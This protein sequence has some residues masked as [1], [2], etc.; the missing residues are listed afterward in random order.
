[1]NIIK[2]GRQRVILPI[3]QPEQVLLDRLY[4][5]DGAWTIQEGLD[6]LG[7]DRL[8]AMIDHQCLGVTPT[9]MGDLLL[10]LAHGRIATY[11]G[12]SASVSLNGQIN[13]AYFRLSL[14]ALG[15]RYPQPGEPVRNLESYDPTGRFK[16]VNTEFGLALVAGKLTSDGYSTD[17][18]RR[19]T[20][21][22]K[23][24]AL[25]ENFY[26]I[27]LTPNARRGRQHAAKHGAFLK[28]IQVLPEHP[29]PPEFDHQVDGRADRRVSTTPPEPAL[30]GSFWKQDQRY[31]SLPPGVLR[32]L[33]MPRDERVEQAMLSIECDGVMSAAQLRSYYGLI[34]EDLQGIHR[35]QTILRTTPSQRTSEVKVEF[36]TL[37]R[38]LARQEMHR[39]A[40]RCGTGRIR[41]LVDVRPDPAAYKAEYR[42]TLKAEEPDAVI[43]GSDGRELAVEFDNG[44]YLR[45]VIDR[46]LGAFQ[47]RGFD[48]VIWG[49][50]N[51]LRQRNLT[52]EIG[53]QLKREILLAEW[54]K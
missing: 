44:T 25:F 47:D 19:M 31:L 3:T 28:V 23:S 4:R 45:R 22:L 46:K 21:R 14:Q 49:V 37:S 42:G 18:L 30:A 40:H 6:A 54:W 1:M 32:T 34:P 17:Y 7:A 15:W 20:D 52:R 39:L 24:T 11:G 2:P 29:T 5:L 16:E 8:R 51:P 36:L 10:L 26:V 41:H 9:A 13:Q 12:A 35:I 53:S 50:S 27:V 33:Q 43:F 38:R 48:E